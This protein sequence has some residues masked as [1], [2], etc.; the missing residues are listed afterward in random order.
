[1]V[2]T[3]CVLMLIHT[4]YFYNEFSLD[5][6]FQI[7]S[8]ETCYCLY[9]CLLD[10]AFWIFTSPT[11]I[12]LYRAHRGVRL[13][14]GY[15]ADDVEWVMQCYRALYCNMS[16]QRR[17]FVCPITILSI[18]DLLIQLQRL[19]LALQSV[20]R[21]VSLTVIAALRKCRSLTFCSSIRPSKKLHRI[22]AV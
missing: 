3:K 10:T 7:F 6:L 22:I 4:N 14:K 21:F 1:M 2:D 15:D 16:A 17:S 20:L 19:H 13:Y 5:P 18:E 12:G 9:T 11:T 8:V